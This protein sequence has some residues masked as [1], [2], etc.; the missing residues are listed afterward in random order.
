[1]DDFSK[2]L[3]QDFN[4][5]EGG[6]GSN[7]GTAEVSNNVAEDFDHDFSFASRNEYA[8]IGKLHAFRASHH[9]N[10]GNYGAAAEESNA[11]ARCYAAAAN[12]YEGRRKR[13]LPPLGSVGG[14]SQ[15]EGG[16]ESSSEGG[17]E[18]SS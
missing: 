2:D 9:S 11:A 12:T 7:F 3:T 17:A 8:A 5:G 4:V 6:S 16:A 15:G 10:V 1:M 14:S 18:R 13:K